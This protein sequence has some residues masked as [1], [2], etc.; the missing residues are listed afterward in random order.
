MGFSEGHLAR[1]VLAQS[2]GTSRCRKQFEE[3]GAESQPFQNIDQKRKLKMRRERTIA[4]TMIER[5]RRRGGG[6]ENRKTPYGSGAS[7]QSI[8]WSPKCQPSLGAEKPGEG[9]LA[10]VA[11]PILSAR[12]LPQY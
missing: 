7:R 11:T 6:A 3:T 8:Q 12:S 1:D 9:K 4:T 5:I 2:G 10:M